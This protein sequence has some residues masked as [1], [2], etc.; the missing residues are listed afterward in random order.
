MESTFGYVSVL[1][2][3]FSAYRFEALQGAPLD[4]YF[5]LESDENRLVVEPFSANMYLAED[6]IMGFEMLVKKDCN[7]TLHFSLSPFSLSHSQHRYCNNRYPFKS[8]HSNSPATAVAEWFLLR[9]TVRSQRVESTLHRIWAQHWKK[10]PSHSSTRVHVS[11]SLFRLYP[12]PTVVMTLTQVANMYLTF[13]IVL[14]SEF[15]SSSITSYCLN[16]IYLT[17]TGIQVFLFTDSH[18]V[19]I[20]PGQRSSRQQG[21]ISTFLHCVWSSSHVHHVPS[22]R[23]HPLTLVTFYSMTTVDAFVLFAACAS[24]FVIIVCSI[25]HGQLFSI[26]PTM[27]QYL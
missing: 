17:I 27:I 22:I 12:F 6:R 13:A 2:G 3:A 5:L 10:A 9:R 8:Q 16:A 11:E 15:G 4:K 23:I 25:I 14:N 24:T 19:R 20:C 21:S 1:P 7:Y 18:L 26:L